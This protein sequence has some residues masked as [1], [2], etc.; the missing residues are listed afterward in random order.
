MLYFIVASDFFVSGMSQCTQLIYSTSWHCI[1]GECLSIAV[2][3]SREIALICARHKPA[4]KSLKQKET[5][6]RTHHSKTGTS[7]TVLPGT[8][9]ACLYASIFTNSSNSNMDRQVKP[10]VVERDDRMSQTATSMCTY[11]TRLGY[12]SPY[13]CLTSGKGNQ[14]QYQKATSSK[15]RKEK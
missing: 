14:R 9:S 13:S 7:W 15:K 6:Q 12:P 8:E 5:G 2:M 3:T 4:T 11:F 10:T 1:S